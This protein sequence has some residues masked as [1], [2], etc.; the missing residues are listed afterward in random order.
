[1]KRILFAVFMAVVVVGMAAA[2]F[3]GGTTTVAVSANVLGTC[4][5]NS[6][7]AIDY[8]NLDPSVGANVNGA[9]TNPSFWCTKN[10]AWTISDDNGLNE[11]G[12]IYRMKGPG[13]TDYIPYSF[14]YTTTG[15]G[16]GK[17]TPISMNITS[18]ILGTD[19]ENASEGA[20]GDTVTLTIAP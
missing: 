14:T 3:A 4:Q 16:A 13:A 2:A 17:T 12:V 5:F 18:S 6:G 8:G 1:M 9:V 10:A 11:A 7:G 15:S 20:Y 19:Y